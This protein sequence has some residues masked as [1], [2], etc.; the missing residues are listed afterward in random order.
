MGRSLLAAALL[1]TFDIHVA[2]AQHANDPWRD[3]SPHRVGFVGPVGHRIQYL[4]WGGHGATL[5]LL[6]GWTLGRA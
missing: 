2:A 4:D 1:V 6:H 5:V 3:T